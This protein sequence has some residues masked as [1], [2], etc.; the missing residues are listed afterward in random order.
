[1]KIVR[2]IVLKNEPCYECSKIGVICK[3]LCKACY[4]KMRRNTPQG[5]EASKLYNATKGKEAV[6]RYLSKKPPKPPKPPKEKCECG[7]ISLAKGLCRN[8][9]QKNYFR[10]KNGFVRKGKSKFNIDDFFDK[11]LE[12]V[13]NGMNIS[14]ACKLYNIDSTYLYKSMTTA[15]KSELISYKITATLNNKI[16]KEYY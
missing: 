12:Q 5:K 6:K 11:I 4:S 13:K 2:I 15:Q 16:R 1:M 8:C 10:K 7:K 9:Y 3:G 14:T